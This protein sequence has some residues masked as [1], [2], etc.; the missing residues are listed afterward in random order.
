MAPMLGTNVIWV[1]KEDSSLQP[2]VSVSVPSWCVLV[3]T[4]LWSIR[5]HPTS[6]FPMS[7]PMS[8]FQVVDQNLCPFSHKTETSPYTHLFP[9]GLLRTT[10]CICASRAALP[11]G[12]DA[13]AE[14]PDSPIWPA[15]RVLSIEMNSGFLSFP[16]CLGRFLN[17][18]YLDVHHATSPVLLLFYVARSMTE[19]SL[20]AF[21]FLTF[22]VNISSVG[23]QCVFSL[24]SVVGNILLRCLLAHL[25]KSCFSLWL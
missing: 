5:L 6:T 21:L 3:S 9:P 2:S 14:L 4:R 16:V 17:M 24:R 12:P 19:P 15:E 1:E 20:R 23:F 8:T 13:A 18:K 7:L 11:A 10:L 22:W 25:L